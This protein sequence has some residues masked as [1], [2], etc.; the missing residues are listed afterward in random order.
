MKKILPILL[1]VLGVLA[2]G[3]AG[4]FLRPPPEVPVET[5]M[6]AEAKKEADAEAELD[7]AAALEANPSAFVK[8][9]NQF[10]VPVVDET[11]VKSLVVLSISLKVAEESSEVVYDREPLLRDVFLQVLFDHAYL[12]GFGGVYTEYSKMN[13]LKSSLL[14]AAQG[15]IGKEVQRILITDIVRQD[16]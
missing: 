2:G 4:F 10:V 16:L 8:M 14:K 1:V 6:D 5:D 13:L 3:G 9:N 15:V 11:R 7:D 12:D